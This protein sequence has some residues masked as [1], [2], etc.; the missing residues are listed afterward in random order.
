[1]YRRY[2]IWFIAVLFA[3]MQG[4][5]VDNANT[6]SGGSAATGCPILPPVRPIRKL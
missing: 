2:L 3:V 4:C 5:G 1:M 6:S